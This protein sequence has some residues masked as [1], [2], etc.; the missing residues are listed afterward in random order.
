MK[1]IK[2]IANTFII[3][4]FV[5]TGKAQTTNRTIDSII[6]LVT[7]QSY[8]AHFDSLRVNEL[9]NRKVIAAPL[10][11][12]DHDECQNYIFRQLQL[13]LGNEQVY[14]HKFDAN[15][16]KGL[17]N[18]IAFKK[19]NDPK[20]GI[21]I[22]GAHYDTNNN[23]DKSGEQ[24]N[25]SPGAN[26]NGTG[27]AALLEI[28][29][30]VSQLETKASVIFAAW[31]IEE[32]FTNGKATGSDRWFTDKVSRKKNTEWGAI[33]NGGTINQYD[34]RANLN[35]DMFG[36]PQQ[37]ENGKPVLWACFATNNDIS[38]VEKYAS[39]LNAYVPQIRTNTFGK[40]VYSDHYTFS[41]RQILSVENLESKYQNDPF[42]HSFADNLQNPDNINMEFATNV[43]RGGLAFLLENIW[44]ANTNQS[45]I[46]F[47]QV[48]LSYNEAPFEYIIKY[49]PSN[50]NI[51][52]VNAYGCKQ[53]Y[54]KQNSYFSFTPYSNGLYF[55]E[56]YANDNYE[57][58][59]LNLHQKERPI[60]DRPFH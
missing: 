21:W 54:R 16:Y 38:F 25:T 40:L 52:I 57:K 23:L 7:V 33:R 19:G 31:D 12:N 29:R 58:A 6:H 44:N 3:G 32:V 4:L 14:L 47:Q 42:Y 45:I 17:A 46:V 55:V 9:C 37:E 48:Q 35:F 13:Y 49:K 51:K 10:Q 56:I 20:A 27:I 2:L 36:N 15:N 59:I 24:K 1:A 28:A 34:L 53:E 18:V 43:T 50:T 22:I 5:I 39:T 41:A 8:S 60:I 26:D 30:I 11:S